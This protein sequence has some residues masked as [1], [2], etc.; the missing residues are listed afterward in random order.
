MHEQC[1]L[2]RAGHQF[3]IY[4]KIGK[5]FFSFLGFRLESHTRPDVGR[6]QVGVLHRIM[7][8]SEFLVVAGAIKPGAFGFHFVTWRG[9][10][11]YVEIENLRGLQPSVADVIRISDPC[12]GFAGNIRRVAQ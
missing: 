3:R 6:H 9:R 8:I 12:H 11:M 7:W 10:D 2:L 5:I 1:I 4:P